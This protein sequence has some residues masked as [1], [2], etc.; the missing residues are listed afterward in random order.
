MEKKKQF[1]MMDEGF[2]CVICGKYVNP[3]KYTARDHCP[4]C[5]F[6]KH[7]DDNP[8]DR[9]N[10]CHGILEPVAVEPSKK[11]LY[12][13]IYVCQKCGEIKK[14][15]MAEDDNMNIIMKLVSNPQDVLKLSKNRRKG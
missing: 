13:I 12:K 10:N 2:S 7:V 6:S 5:L 15:I 11:A 8:G 3:L 9:G 4:N 14:N 1:I